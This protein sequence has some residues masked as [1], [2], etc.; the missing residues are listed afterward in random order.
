MAVEYVERFVRNPT[1]WT[2]ERREQ[3]VKSEETLDT[4]DL[5][6]VK[7]RKQRRHARALRTSEQSYDKRSILL[8]CTNMQKR[9]HGS[10]GAL[11]SH[12]AI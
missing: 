11:Q 10:S 1:E 5:S 2:E 4:I 8:A 12:D 7:T 3:S 9:K 6:A